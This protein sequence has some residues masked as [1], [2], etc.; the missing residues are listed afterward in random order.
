MRARDVLMVKKLNKYC[1]GILVYNYFLEIQRNS[2]YNRSI[3][4]HRYI[5]CLREIEIQTFKIKYGYLIERKQTLNKLTNT[6]TQLFSSNHTI[7]NE[8]VPV[9]IQGRHEVNTFLYIFKLKCSRY[10]SPK[11]TYVVVLN[12]QA[13]E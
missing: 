6:S 2:L 9:Y 10:S 7:W 4:I 3:S 13:V 8:K 12:N 1:L 11:Y 5:G